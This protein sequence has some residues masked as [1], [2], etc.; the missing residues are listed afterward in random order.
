MQY[1]IDKDISSYEGLE[2]V[3]C[4]DVIYLIEIGMA[5]KECTVIDKDVI[6]RG[7][8]VIDYLCGSIL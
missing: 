3:D 1:V 2:V 5:G 4:L 6:L 8:A 7:V